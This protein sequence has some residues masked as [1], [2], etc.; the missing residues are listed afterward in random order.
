MTVKAQIRMPVMGL[1][2]IVGVQMTEEGISGLNGGRE[3][4]TLY[5]D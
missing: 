4:I 3:S 5:W 2:E 1:S